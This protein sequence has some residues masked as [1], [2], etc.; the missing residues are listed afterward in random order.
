MSNWEYVRLFGLGE[1]QPSDSD[2]SAIAN[3]IKSIQDNTKNNIPAAYTYFG[4]FISHDLTH[5]GHGTREPASTF[6]DLSKITL[7]RNPTLN[8]DSIYGGGL[9]DSQIPFD[10]ATGAFCLGLDSAGASNDLP[11]EDNGRAR[12]G[13][14]RNDE[15]LLIAQF[16]VLFMKL[17]NKRVLKHHS[18]GD[19]DPQSLFEKSRQEV[20]AIYQHLVLHDFAKRI[21]P[22]P[23]VS[24]SGERSESLYEVIINEGAGKLI[25][26]DGSGIQ[27]SA[28]LTGAALR[29]GHSMVDTQYDLNYRNGRNGE[30]TRLLLNELFT[31]TSTHINFQSP[32]GKENI[33]DWQFFVNFEKYLGKDAQKPNLARK[34]DLSINPYMLNIPGENAAPDSCPASPD[35]D[36]VE[37]N[38]QRGRELGLKSGQ[39]ICQAL[40]EKHPDVANRLRLKPLADDIG[41]FQSLRSAG[42]HAMALHTPLWVYVLLEADIQQDSRLGALGG[43]IVADGLLAA[44]QQAHNTTPHSWTVE[45]LVLG[46]SGEA[47]G[48]IRAGNDPVELADVVA[49]VYPDLVSGNHSTH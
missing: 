10:Q 23:G 4:Q 39:E 49:F 9:A 27:I 44:A 13:D 45:D 11:R 17:H 40:F 46:E 32:L 15:N 8:L 33:I 26:R 42:N 19:N 25:P 22:G 6:D 47:L 5:L 35:I 43:W 36:I 37:R 18:A 29:F 41:F 2:I 38:I 3:Q 31:Q 12:I 21:L 34:I 14:L 48:K 7:R 30:K 16:Q 28:E 20:I 1:N 24:R